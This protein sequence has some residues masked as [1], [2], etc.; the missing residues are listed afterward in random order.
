MVVQY[1]ED[2]P[3]AWYRWVVSSIGRPLNWWEFVQGLEAIYG[4]FPTINY[5]G[6]LTKL[7]LEYAYDP[8]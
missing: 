5:F 4:K 7:E 8:Y 3:L 2:S 6:E 1:S